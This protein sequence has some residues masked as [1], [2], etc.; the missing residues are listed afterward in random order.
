MNNS[1]LI[2]KYIATFIKSD[3]FI[4]S[5]TGGRIWPLIINKKN[6]EIVYPLIVYARTGDN[7]SYD[8]DGRIKDDLSITIVIID[9]NYERSLQLAN[10]VRKCLE[11]K[12][13]QDE[14]IYISDIRL[15][16]AYEDD[17]DNYYLQTLNFIFTIQ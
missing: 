10:A 15:D 5:Q 8:K 14:N 4:N 11:Y 3:D 16:N 9:K 17:A 12:T 13:F 2:G 1:I 7:I 6:D